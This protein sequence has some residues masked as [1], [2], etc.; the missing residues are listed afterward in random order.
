MV[1]EGL[2]T[3]ENARGHAEVAEKTLNA[4]MAKEWPPETQRKPRSPTRNRIAADG[5]SLN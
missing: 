3:A 4:K 5:G 1:I 2:L